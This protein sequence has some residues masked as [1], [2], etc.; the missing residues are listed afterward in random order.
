MIAEMTASRI[1]ALP[2]ISAC[3]LLFLIFGC[4]M[5]LRPHY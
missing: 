4:S 1:I 5:S 2:L 3:A